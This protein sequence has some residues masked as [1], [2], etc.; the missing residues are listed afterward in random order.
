[1][2]QCLAAVLTGIWGI[3]G[4]KGSFVPIRT[5][6]ALA[7]QYACPSPTCR[8]ARTLLTSATS[9]LPRRSMDSLQPSIDFLHFNTREVR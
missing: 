1:M 3:L 2:I 5:T 6:A 7:K 8:R 4:L 9:A